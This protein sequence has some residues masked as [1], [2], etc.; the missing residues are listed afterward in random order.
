MYNY[1]AN[2]GRFSESLWGKNTKAPSLLA[3]IETQQWIRQYIIK[4]MGHTKGKKNLVAMDFSRD[5]HQYLG[6]PWGESPVDQTIKS[7]AIFSIT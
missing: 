7:T 3:D 6:L 2:G 4:L 1:E 5:L